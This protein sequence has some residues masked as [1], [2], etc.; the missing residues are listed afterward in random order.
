MLNA[1]DLQTMTFQGTSLCE[2]LLAEIALVRP[3]ARV[4]SGVPLQ[5]EGVVE[6]LAAKRA[7]VTFH[8]AMAFHVTV[9]ESLEAEV[10]AADATGEAVRVVVLKH[11][12]V[13][14]RFPRTS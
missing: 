2:A 1:V 8:V 4:R 9:Q 5:V 12:F 13:L 6:A 3:Y 14:T 10:F 7:Q 11:S